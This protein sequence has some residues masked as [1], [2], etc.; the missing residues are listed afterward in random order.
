MLNEVSRAPRIPA[1]KNSL[2]ATFARLKSEDLAEIATLAISELD[3][4]D[5]DADAEDGDDDRCEAHDDNPASVYVLRGLE[6]GAGDPGDAEDDGLIQI[7]RHHFG[8]VDG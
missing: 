7:C 8:L 5:G 2:A 6:Q 3:V 4:R 1:N